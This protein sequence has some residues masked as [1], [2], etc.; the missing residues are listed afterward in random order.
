VLGT[1]RWPRVARS[2]LDCFGK[3]HGAALLRLTNLSFIDTFHRA[4]T[5]AKH[6]ARDKQEP[7]MSRPTP[8]LAAVTS[9]TVKTHC[10]Y[11]AFQ[12][13]MEVTTTRGAT[14]QLRIVA[15]PDFPVNRGQMCIKG[16]TSSEL[17]DHPQRILQPQLRQPSG[18]LAP[19]SWQHALDFI[20]ERLRALQ[21]S[22]GKQSVGVFGSGALTNEKAYLLGKF[23][24]VALGTPNIDYNGRYCMSSAAA[25]QNRA[26]GIDRGL[27]F[28]V[29]DIAEAQTLMLWGSNCAETM[30]PIMQ[31]VYA[32][33]D[34]GGQLIVVDPRLTDT[35]RGA[36]LHLQ[37]T[38]GTDLLLANGL[39][40]IALEQNLLDHDYIAARTEGF[41]ELRRNL[42][43]MDTTFVERVTGVSL[44]KQVRAVQ[45]L[46]RAESSM[47]LSGRG[48]EQQSKGTA[49]VLSF[50]NLML[51][52]GKV[53]KPASGYGC[54]T[55]QGNGQG[56]REHG[57]KADQLPGYRLIED[58]AHRA[59]IA[60]VWGVSPESLPGKG[61]SAYELLDSMG[62]KGGVRAMLVFGSNVVVA[63]P[64]ASNIEA[65]LKQLDLLVV[66]DAFE[67]ETAQDAH[68]ILPIAQFGE[69]E[70]TLTNL[71]GRVILREQVRKAPDGVKTD[72]E[73]LAELAERLGYA[74]GFRFDSAEAVFEELRRATAGGK[75]DYSGISYARIREEK[76]V[77]WPCPA[78]NHPGTPRL[79][80]ER[81]AFPNGRA[82]FHVVPH[83]PAAE[84]PD[85]DYPLFFTTGRYKEHYNSGAQTRRVRQL[86]DAK[87]DPRVQIHPRLAQ[88]LGILE[89]QSIVVES[90]RGSVTMSTVISRDIRPDTLFAPFHWGGKQAANI[91]T[92]PAL[93]PFSR[94]PEFKICAVRA[95]SASA[96]RGPKRPK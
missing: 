24:R 27:P 5:A 90:R 91:L 58:P 69:E 53:G 38:P 20:A 79:F 71:E 19:V 85:A 81:F 89:G 44:D 22:Y 23:A 84:L 16:F 21:Q 42:L 40:A 49:T 72:L 28:P 59:A 65:K 3:E 11:C 17:L 26:F 8:H 95:G 67:N 1:A 35:A 30:P 56:G 10:P 77:F 41:E 33:K 15:N 36:A 7:G 32:Q 78:P 18:R 75:A 94:M 88:E 25:G 57:Q 39:L 74:E 29:S 87:P 13:G 46:A 14:T 6:G 2:P 31:W 61:K 9:Q 50:T 64:N 4:D 93:D 48:A 37:P 92:M 51:A 62:P 45:L 82:R 52:L 68:V 70:G 60:K 73:I 47:L 34:R 83:Q 63:S 43:A 96:T 66:C 12:C 86:E 54:L 55:G 80:S 76:G